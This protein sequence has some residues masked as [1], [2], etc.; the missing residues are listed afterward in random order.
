LGYESR[1]RRG[2][3]RLLERIVSRERRLDLD[4]DRWVIFS[5]HHRGQRDGADD[6]RR[7]EAAYNAAL[8]YY[9]EAGHRLLLLGDVEEL[10]ESTPSSVLGSYTY[11]L[12]LEAQFFEDDR[13]DR[14]WGN[15]DDEWESRGCV[16]DHFN[17]LYPGLDIKE[18]DAFRV[19]S[20]GEE[21]G[22]LFLV[23]GHQ[24][25][26]TSD[27][28]RTATRFAI[29][30][31]WRPVQ[32]FIRKP[33]TTPARNFILR[34]RH[35]RAIYAWASSQ[36][37]MVV[38]AGHTHRPVF[39]GSSHQS[40]MEEQLERLFAEAKAGIDSPADLLRVAELR[41]ELEWV[42]VHGEDPPGSAE[43]ATEPVKPCYF[44]TGCCSFG[45]GSISGIEISDG[46]IKLIRWPDERGVPKPRVLASAD[47]RNEVF[48]AL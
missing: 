4:V 42:R 2:L 36:Q 41:A 32:R 29:R 31:A 38:I 13:Y 43:R 19:T 46:R 21:L 8:G 5:D 40:R 7:C 1:K 3:E 35:D 28:F 48:A 34:N 22:T 10:W 23:H 30:N 47:L 26:H 37:R 20:A 45:D 11:T 17:A 16:K 18:G 39:M 12:D 6:F 15:H 24:G 27:R 14:Y 9:F 44:N 25:S 33:S